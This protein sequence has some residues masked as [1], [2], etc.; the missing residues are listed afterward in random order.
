[1]NR[2]EFIKQLSLTISVA[3]T[4][5]T[6]YAAGLDISNHGL[7]LR[8][9]PRRFN[10]LF[11]LADQWRF[12][13]LGHGYNHDKVVRT[14]HL[15]R[16]S[17]QGAHWT[18][19]YATHP[20]CTPN[21]SALITGRWPWQTGMNANDLMLPPSERC[22][23][24][25]FTEAGYNC[26]YI[27]KWHM[28]G[29]G[30]TYPNGYVPRDWHR[31]GFTT[32]EG[33]NRGHN[34][35]Y[36]NSFMM[37]NE[38]VEMS[39]LGLYPG[40]TYEPAFQTDLAIQFIK[41]SKK[42]PFFCFLSWG[43]PHTPYADHP[44]EYT[45]NASDIVVRP[46]VPADKVSAAKNSLK[47]Y[48]AHCTAMDFE[49]GRLMDALEK[50][51]LA[52][53]TLVVFSADHG[54]LHQ[55]HNLTY[56]GEP[57]EESWHVP[58]LMRLP[59]KIKSGQFVEH[60][61]SSADLMPT[62][63][64]LCGLEAP[65]TCTGKDKSAALSEAGLPDESIYGGV[66]DQWRAVVKGDYKLVIEGDGVNQTP[67]KLYDLKT[68]PYEMDNLISQPDYQVIKND[69]L[70]EIEIWKNKTEDSFPVKPWNAETSY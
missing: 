35:W 8:L 50:E 42:Q 59:G 37:T 55:S 66:Q 32:F 69:L 3:S 10:L 64:S 4:G 47:D 23:A 21:R 36:S 62:L 41:Q 40:N 51:G 25:E 63:L 52:D 24:H 26:H 60:L 15:D 31:R 9:G 5:I 27:G 44:E 29:A 46:N 20:V 61:I 39:T 16:F 1:M 19:C 57:E 14:P 2:R 17:K 6:S 33:F 43:P 68:D 56:K 49:F 54:D 67:V 13:A 7:Q 53:N 34:Y 45:Y 70:A 48:F 22:I 65:K 11:V 12:C 30:K 18:R 38:G 58:L 28:N